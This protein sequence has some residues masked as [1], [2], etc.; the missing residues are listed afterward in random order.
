MSPYPYD[1]EGGGL[2][3]GVFQRM[4]RLAPVLFYSPRDPFGFFSNFSRHKVTIYGRTWA[5]SEHAFQAMKYH[6]H[7]PDLMDRV[8][9]SPTPRGAAEVGRDRTLPLRV[10]W[11]EPVEQGTLPDGPPVPIHAMVDDSRG[12]ARAIENFRDAIMYQVVFEKFS[13]HADLRKAILDTGEAPIIEDAP[14]DFYWG[15]GSSREGVNRLGK[16]LMVARAVLGRE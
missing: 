12:P 6:P 5:T 1:A 8:Y 15:W 4:P 7:R 3:T 16:V 11:D 10:G 9:L 14:R 2:S 13:Q